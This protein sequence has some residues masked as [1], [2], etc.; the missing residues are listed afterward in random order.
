M[1]ETLFSQAYKGVALLT[2]ADRDLYQALSSYQELGHIGLT[3]EKKAALLEA[4][5]QE[6]GRPSTA[7][8]RR[9]RRWSRTRPPGARS[10]S[11]TTA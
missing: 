9:F 7:P 3:Q 1:R 6:A 4:F 11:P 5:G 2:N 8:R 10:S